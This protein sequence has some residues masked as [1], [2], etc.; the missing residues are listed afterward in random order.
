MIQIEYAALRSDAFKKS[1]TKVVTSDCL[2]I[3]V[4]SKVLKL[5]KALEAAISETQKEWISVAEEIIERSPEGSFKVNDEGTDFKWLIGVS[6]DQG[7]KIVS[8]FAKS[9]IDVAADCLSLDELTGAKLSA[10][11]LGAL[12]PVIA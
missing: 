12:E 6:P 1:F 2:G 4:S 3:E 11:D 5:A 10:E 9:K 8:D 7:Q